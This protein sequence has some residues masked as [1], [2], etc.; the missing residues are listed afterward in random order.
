MKSGLPSRSRVTPRTQTSQNDNNKPL[1]FPTVAELKQTPGPWVQRKVTEMRGFSDLLHLV[2]N[3]DSGNRAR[4]LST[5]APGSGAFVH[6]LP[7][8]GDLTMSRAEMLG[9]IRFR[10][11]MPAA[12]ASQ[13]QDARCPC[14]QA[15]FAKCRTLCD[16]SAFE[17]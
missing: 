15:A 10:L 7:T 9:A 17:R 3:A 8:R 4:L 6:A 11:G 12:R 2:R 14:G 5:G 13:L 1:E 16:W